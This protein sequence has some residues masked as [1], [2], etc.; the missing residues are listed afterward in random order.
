[1]QG[2]Y[3]SCPCPSPLPHGRAAARR[4]GSAAGPGLRAMHAR[5]APQ[6]NTCRGI[7]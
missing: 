3:A 1:M 6:P 2:A 4:H 7:L 5:H